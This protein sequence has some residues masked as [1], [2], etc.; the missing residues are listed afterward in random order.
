MGIIYPGF[1]ISAFLSIFTC[2]RRKSLWGIILSVYF[3]VIDIIGWLIAVKKD[4]YFLFF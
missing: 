1:F 3:F 2:I 4:F